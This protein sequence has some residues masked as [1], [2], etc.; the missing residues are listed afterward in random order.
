TFLAYKLQEQGKQLVKIDKWF[1]ST[2]ICSCCG[3]KKEMPLCERTYAYVFL[4]VICPVLY[5]Y[6]VYTN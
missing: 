2:K 5:F 1:P 3:N 4:L 6:F